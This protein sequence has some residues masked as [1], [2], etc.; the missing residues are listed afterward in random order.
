M[1]PE[2]KGTGLLNTSGDPLAVGDPAFSGKATALYLM[3][4][5]AYLKEAS[6][7]R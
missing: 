5:T 2:K 6:G 1:I 3:D 7:P 4:T